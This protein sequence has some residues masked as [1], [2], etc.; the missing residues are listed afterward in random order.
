LSTIYLID[1]YANNLD[2]AMHRASVATKIASA[3]I[4]LGTIIFSATMLTLVGQFLIILLFQ[5]ASKLPVKRLVIWALYPAFF[6]VIFAISQAHYSVELSAQTMLR[7]VDAALLMLLLIGT[8]PFTRIIAVLGKT[9]RTLSNLAFFSYRFFFLFADES[10]RRLTA[11][12]VRG[13]FQ[14]AIRTRIKNAANLIGLLFVS[15]MESSEK[16]YDAVK[17]RGY[18]GEFSTEASLLGGLTK[19][20][21][22]PVLLACVTVALFLA[23]SLCV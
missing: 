20:D 5:F 6:A 3:V 1:D 8:T 7:A 21:L 4:A 18:R 12:R 13:G 22:A 19:Y 10:S 2:S 17:T 15:Y 11:L 9:S 14:G 23:G 16:V